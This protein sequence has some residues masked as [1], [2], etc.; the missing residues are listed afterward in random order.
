[1]KVYILVHNVS[2]SYGEGEETEILDVYSD[3]DKMIEIEAKFARVSEIL[4]E[5]LSKK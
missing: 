5:R 2:L 4:K 3:F 1:M